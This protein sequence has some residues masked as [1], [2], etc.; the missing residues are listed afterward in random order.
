M[1]NQ[2]YSLLVDQ[3]SNRSKP[4]RSLPLAFLIGGIICC[5][6]Q[7]LLNLYTRLGLDK[8]VAGAC[9]SISL[10]FLA[11]L[12]T[13]LKVYDNIAKYGGAGALV[14]ITGFSNSMTA[15]AMEFKSEG[16]ILGLGAKIFT[17]AGPVIVYG[18]IA[19]IIYGLVLYLF[20]LI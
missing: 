13:G 8:D 4:W 19:S 15:A 6:G 11:A 3:L 7:F 18:T 17:I 9:V 1:T 20:K 12:L 2:D 10:V 16:L 14:P 5:I